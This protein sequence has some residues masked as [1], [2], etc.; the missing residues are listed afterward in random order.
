MT[1]APAPLEPTPRTDRGIMSRVHPRQWPSLAWVFYLVVGGLVLLAYYLLPSVAGNGVLFNLI[2]LS[3]AAAILLGVRLHK[4]AA[5]RAWALFALGQMLFVSGDMFHYGY[6][7]VFHKSVPFPS[8]A[9]LLYLGVYPCLVAGLL[10]F[11]KRRSPLGDRA[12]LIDALIVTTGLAL[13]AWVF[14]I[15]PYAHDPNL[16]MGERLV[17][18]AYP[19]MDVLLLAVFIRLTVDKGK[20]PP[21]LMLLFGSSIALLFADVTLGLLTLGGG[22]QEGGLLDIGW[23]LYYLLW[24]AAALHP[25]MRTLDEASPTR[26]A[27]LTRRRIV[28]L[29][30]ASL[31][32]PAT[33]AIQALRGESSEL[34]VMVTGSAVLF[35]LVVARMTGLL[36]DFERSAHREKGLREA[37]EA[38]V[39]AGSGSEVYAASLESML[40]L[41]GSSREARLC[42]LDESGA[43]CVGAASGKMGT[44]TEA[45]SVP[46]AETVKLVSQGLQNRLPTHITADERLKD[47]LRLPAETTNDIVFP[48]F[49]RERFRGLVLIS[50]H[51]TLPGRM[52]D[53][54][55]TLAAN[56]ALA[57]ES[58]AL[59]DDLH[60]RQSEARFRSLVQHASDLIT[61][62]EADS[63]ISYQSPSVQRV[64]GYPSEQ[65]IGQ[66]LERLL[67]PD[68]RSRMLSLLVE[69]R[70]SSTE[71]QTLE[72]RLRHQDGTWLNFEI[73]RTDLMHDENVGGIVLNARDISER[74]A[75]ERQLTHQAFHDPVTNLANRAL[76]S[77][78]VQHALSRQAREKSGL[79]VL[80]IDLDDFK[81]IND[82]LGHGPGD[83]V[84]AEVGK[85]LTR[86]VRPMDTVARFGGDE[87]AILLEDLES[88]GLVTEVADR[89]LADLGDALNVEGKQVSALASVGIATVFGDQ[90]FTLGA[91]ELMRNADVAMYSAKRNGKGHY[92]LFEPDMHAAVLERLELKG[93]LQRA[94]HEEE[95][96]LHYQPVVTLDTERISGFE[97]LVRWNHPERGYVQPLQ[98]IPLAEETGL[99]LPLGDWVLREACKQAAVLQAAYPRD[100]ALTMSVN[101]SARQLQHRGLVAEVMKALADSKVDPT[102]IILEITESVLMTDTEAAIMKLN[103]LK[104]LGVRVAID[105]F[106]TGYSS[107]SYLSRFPVDILKIDQ[108]FVSQLG[109]QDEDSALAGAIVKLSEALS[110]QTV[111]EGIEL[112]DQMDRLVQLGCVSGQGFH[113]A[114]PMSIEGALSHL[115]G[116]DAP[117][118][119]DHSLDRT[120]P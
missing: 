88:L 30:C 76:F 87:F 6:Q 34:A 51:D 64:L 74:K 46:P 108:S 48:L 43:L 114:K 62:V 70:G 26:E 90:A 67:H 47:A 2:G 72:C 33:Q 104:G 109:E 52:I 10:L 120:D 101:L 118:A 110:L 59:T 12:S 37:G 113:F 66:K 77:D 39:G 111:A 3:S 35:L 56:V 81:I 65:I 106:G 42:L 105:D 84:L 49:V 55:Q 99:I 97:A 27:K 4:P 41:V 115:L 73:L 102:T 24:G 31:I 17:S 38:L 60:R 25:S 19:A 116:E 28:L 32:A 53:S 29:T 83:Q 75:F 36:H 9:D 79:A 13:L 93:D 1:I 11:I 103:E 69:G 96:V 89:V 107:L 22:Y 91:D 23:S 117:V 92:M 40:S 112:A 16:S 71:S 8:A 85:R 68:E 18:I 58:A 54:L 95:F 94:L 57:I 15:A 21:A 5:T 61:V 98:F 119:A 50:G 80:F 86:C 45:W 20:R 63:T 44:S 82:S 100:P 78:R 7:S 14:L